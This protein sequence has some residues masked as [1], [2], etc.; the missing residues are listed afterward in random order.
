METGPAASRRTG[1]RALSDLHRGPSAAPAGV[2]W[3]PMM[4]YL[5]GEQQAISNAGVLVAAVTGDETA[6]RWRLLHLVKRKCWAEEPAK[7]SHDPPENGARF[8]SPQR[9]QRS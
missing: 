3:L 5:L 9:T 4:S 6:G 1:R 8:S 2:A 7:G